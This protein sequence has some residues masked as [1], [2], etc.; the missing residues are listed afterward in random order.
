MFSLC[1]HVSE[2]HADTQISSI[3]NE[4]GNDV[5]PGQPGEAWLKGP[6]ITRGYHRNELANEEAFK[7][8]WYRTGDL[9]EARGDLLYV[10]GRIKVNLDQVTMLFPGM[11]N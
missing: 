11:H 4:H 8:G 5:D 3:V 10:V 7:D 6:I 9:V 1:G 2:D